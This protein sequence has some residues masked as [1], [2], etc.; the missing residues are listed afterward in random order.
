MTAFGQCTFNNATSLSLSNYKNILR[1]YLSITLHRYLSFRSEIIT[2]SLL[3]SKCKFKL[4]SKVSYIRKEN[5][6]L[7]FCLTKVAGT[8]DASSQRKRWPPGF[9]ENTGRC[10][11]FPLTFATWCDHS[12]LPGILHLLGTRSYKNTNLC[13]YFGFFDIHCEWSVFFSHHD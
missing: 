6:F 2:C 4:R 10:V 3:F 8:W 12:Y 13:L 9:P 7:L 11:Q 5:H 1:S